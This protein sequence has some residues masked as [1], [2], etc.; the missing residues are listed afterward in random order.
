M[1]ISSFGRT[2]YEYDD[3]NSAPEDAEHSDEMFNLW[4]LEGFCL[5]DSDTRWPVS[6]H[7]IAKDGALGDPCSGNAGGAPTTGVILIPNSQFVEFLYQG[8]KTCCNS[9]HQ[10]LNYLRLKKTNF[11]PALY[12]H[13]IER[14]CSGMIQQ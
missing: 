8:C 3:C 9:I 1:I 11:D 10:V 13:F 5:A 6:K 7:T 14:F 4:D 12:G 2:T